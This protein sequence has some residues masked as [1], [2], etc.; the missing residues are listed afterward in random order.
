[1]RFSV[2]TIAL[3]ALAL[4]RP[5]EAAQDG[6]VIIT[7]A[8]ALAGNVTPGDTP[9]YPIRIS[10]SGSYKLGSNLVV[11]G[12]QHGIVVTAP[13]NVTIDLNGFTMDGRESAGTGIHS[14]AHNLAVKNGSIVSFRN[15]AIVAGLVT[16][17]DGL[18]VFAN[19]GG[20]IDV[21][22]YSRVSNSSFVQNAGIGLKV[23]SWSA[24]QDNLVADNNVMTD[25]A[26]QVDAPF[27]HVHGN[28]IVSHG[29]LAIRGAFT[30]AGD[31][32]VL[33]Q[34]ETGVRLVGVM[35]MR[36]NACMS[37]E[38]C[39]YDNYDG[40]APTATASRPLSLAPRKR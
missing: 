22:G 26:K 6:T 29:G 38:S 11:T 28:G 36:P 24:V 33:D 39:P 25:G 4:A 20:G 19:S 8:S 40:G 15:W 35:P 5:A 10:R 31:N 37:D 34:D 17:V 14:R 18:R 27:S 2:I 7:Q 3:A 9:G 23:G 32:T 16:T 1:M 13:Q 21:G 30:G 12:G